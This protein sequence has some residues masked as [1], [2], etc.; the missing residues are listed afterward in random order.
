MLLLQ[1]CASGERKGRDGTKATHRKMPVREHREVSPSLHSTPPTPFPAIRPAR[2]QLSLHAH[3][4]SAP[5][6]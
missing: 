6:F 4:L 1:D 2:K 3:Q 5:L